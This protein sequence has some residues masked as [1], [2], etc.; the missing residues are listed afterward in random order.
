MTGFIPGEVVERLRAAS[1][2]AVLTGAGISAESGIPTFRD[3]QTGLWSQYHPSELA[4]PQAFLRNPRLVWNWYAY[5]RKMAEA[6]QPNPAHYALVDLEQHYP[7]FTLITQNV[8]GLHWRAGSRDLLEL[9]GNISRVR[10][11][12]CAT[13]VDRWS[14][15]EDGPP[16]CAHCGGYLR[17]D[18]IWFGE[19]LPSRELGMAYRAAEHSDVFL[20]IGTSAVVQPA[21]SLPLIALRGGS[22]VIEINTEDT[23][24]S[25][26]AHYSLQGKAGDILPEL[27]QLVSGADRE[28]AL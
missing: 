8:D 7:T 3:A 27:V 11:F 23:S 28:E 1:R 20:C 12:D 4:T 13:F 6:A 26:M 14:D 25:D 5:R 21:A 2:V 22:Y 15:D 24:L 17:P 18:V 9:H 10:C 16:A 19:G